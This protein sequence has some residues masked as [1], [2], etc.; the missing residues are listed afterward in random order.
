MRGT[1]NTNARGSAEGRRRRKQALLNRDGD[2]T[3]AP[4]WECATPVT[5]RTMVADRIVPGC[6]GGTYRLSNLRVHCRPCSE[7][8]GRRMSAESRRWK[9][10]KRRGLRT[11]RFSPNGRRTYLA[12]HWYVYL[13]GASIGWVGRTS[14]GTR[15][16]GYRYR[17][18]ESEAHLEEDWDGAPLRDVGDRRADLAAYGHQTMRAALYALLLEHTQPKKERQAA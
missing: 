6:R 9:A 17:A 12:G 14:S 10:W 13:D 1:T 15:W 5:A 4:C 7:A 3:T 16:C 2:G 18:P 8:Q 11:S